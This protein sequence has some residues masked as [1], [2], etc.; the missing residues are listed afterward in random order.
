MTKRPPF[1]FR[2][3]NL[4]RHSNFELRLFLVQLFAPIAI[5]F[6]AYYPVLK[7]GFVWDDDR[8]I[9]NNV[10]LRTPGGL[11]KIWLKPLKAEP[12]YYPLTHTSFWIEYHLWGLRPW[13]YHLDNI[14]LHLGIPPFCCGGCWHG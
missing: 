13:G 14:L 2:V 11:E 1:E 9:E 6:A 3:S 5:T 10:Q 4:I 12:Q 7:N 8:Y